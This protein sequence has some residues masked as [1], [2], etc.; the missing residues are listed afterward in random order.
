MTVGGSRSRRT[1]EARLAALVSIALVSVAIEGCGSGASTVV[2][3]PSSP[4]DSGSATGATPSLAATP[5]GTT[6]TAA[7]GATDSPTG[8]TAAAGAPWRPGAGLTW[9]LQC[10]GTIDTSLPVDVFDL[11]VDDTSQRR[12]PPCTRVVAR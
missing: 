6:G 5:T 2:P 4:S 1:L 8:R 7:T 12:S 10:T 9:Q 3:V 11:D